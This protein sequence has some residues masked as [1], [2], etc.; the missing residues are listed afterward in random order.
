MNLFYYK[1]PLG[2]IELGIEAGWIVHAVFIDKKVLG[3]NKVCVGGDIKGVLDEYFLHKK[4]FSKSF[5][6]KYVTI[7]KLH[8]TPFQ[9]KVWSIIA[10]VPYGKTIDYSTLAEKAG[11]VGAARAAG[12]ACGKNPLALF[13]P[14]HRVVRKSGEDY[15]Y[16]WGLE[17]KKYLLTLEGVIKTK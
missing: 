5:L 17:R 1:S 13:I 8:G 9:K 11:K 15:G 10:S 7:G 4:A 16:S 12:S 2:Y 6:K 14:C 3:K